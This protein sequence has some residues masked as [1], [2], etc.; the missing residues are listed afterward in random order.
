MRVEFSEFA[1]GYSL[2]ENLCRDVLPSSNL[3]GAPL[4]PS[5]LAQGQSGGGYETR[6]GIS[7]I[8][9]NNKNLTFSLASY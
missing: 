2:I 5:L 9:S 8:S 1:Y 6:L 7:D 3:I 4:L